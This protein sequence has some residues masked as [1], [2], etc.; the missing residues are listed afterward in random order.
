MTRH[1]QSPKTRVGFWPSKQPVSGLARA[2][3]STKSRASETPFAAGWVT[4]C[5]LPGERA[6]RIYTI[7]SDFTPTF[8]FEFGNINPTL[9]IKTHYLSA[10]IF[11]SYT[12]R[13]CPNTFLL[14]SG[15]TQ[16]KGNLTYQI[17]TSDVSVSKGKA[18]QTEHPSSTS[19][20]HPF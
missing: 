2:A 5:L 20:C 15:L 4:L 14:K 18:I 1:R 6:Y 9:N 19:R 8:R 12:F 11:K 13:Q 17:L 16:R 7:S 10:T 3:P